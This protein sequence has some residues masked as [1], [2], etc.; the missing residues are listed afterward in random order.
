VKVSEIL[1]F[2]SEENRSERAKQA[3]CLVP[4]LADPDTRYQMMRVIDFDSGTKISR[5]ESDD[6]RI[7]HFVW[8]LR[9]RFSYDRKHAEEEGSWTSLRSDWARILGLPIWVR[10]S[11]W[12][13]HPSGSYKGDHEYVVHPC[14][15][16]VGWSRRALLDRVDKFG[17]DSRS[18]DRIDEL[19]MAR[20]V[21]N[22]ECDCFV[23]TPKRLVVIECKD[24]TTFLKEQRTRQKK[25]FEC[26]ERLLPRE[27]P[28]LY[29]E[30]SSDLPEGGNGTSWTW[31][32]IA[33]LTGIEDCA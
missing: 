28:L 9:D 7:M 17:L 19:V 12:W 21:M 25:L 15:R 5:K 27:E 30:L 24:K 20:Q 11:R 31:T 29:V 16:T 13:C 22:T 18:G 4:A 26:L 1:Y 2:T 23:Q 3:M 33:E 8:V 32:Q 10:E 6:A 14:S